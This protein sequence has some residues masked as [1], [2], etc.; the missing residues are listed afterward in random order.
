MGEAEAAY[1]E[2]GADALAAARRLRAGSH[3][4]AHVAAALTQVRL[5]RKAVDKLGEAAAR[6]Y[7]TP[8]GLEQAT[9]GLVAEHRAARIAAAGHHRLLDL[10]CGIGADLVAA[11]SVGITVH[12]VERD[13]VTAAVARANLA[14]LGLTGTVSVGEASEQNRSA[15]DIVFADP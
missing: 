10:G 15:Y 6:M 9:A 7:F 3:D 4:P 1:A 5:R 13:P 14:A 8:V 11:A 12:A 2:T